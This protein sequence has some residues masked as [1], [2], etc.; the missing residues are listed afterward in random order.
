MGLWVMLM[1]SRVGQCSCLVLVYGDNGSNGRRRV[2]VMGRLSGHVDGTTTAQMSSADML[3]L[4]RRARRGRRD[5][6]MSG[7]T[8]RDATIQH[9]GVNDYGNGLSACKLQCQCYVGVCGQYKAQLRTAAWVS[10]TSMQWRWSSS[11]C[12]I[13]AASIRLISNGMQWRRQ[14][15]WRQM[16]AC[17]S[18]GVCKS[19]K[20]G[21][22]GLATAT[23]WVDGKTT[24]KGARAWA[25]GWRK[26]KA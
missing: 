17:N 23:G 26:G 19:I 24:G 14:M 25:S 1:S 7:S 22:D 15:L 16:H 8:A 10:V 4:R 6:E 18:N 2:A 13:N 9:A 21:Y 12:S 20:A 5:R 11:G 3:G